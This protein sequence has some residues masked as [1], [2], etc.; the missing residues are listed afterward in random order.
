[1]EE[2]NRNAGGVNISS[3]VDGF[4]H[5]FRQNNVAG[6]LIILGSDCRLPLLCMLIDSVYETL[7]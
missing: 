6:V 2:N 4:G 5:I 3:T 7:F 1:M